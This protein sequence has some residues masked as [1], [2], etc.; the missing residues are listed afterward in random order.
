MNH[1]PTHTVLITL[2]A[3]ST[4]VCDRRPFPAVVAGTPG[5][6]TPAVDLTVAD[7]N[8]RLGLADDLTADDV[9]TLCASLGVALGAWVAEIKQYAADLQDREDSKGAAA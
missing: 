9:R 3:H 7:T 2:D 5:D 1:N 8:I 6:H 4:A